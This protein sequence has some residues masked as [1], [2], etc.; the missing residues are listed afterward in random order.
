MRVFVTLILI[1]IELTVFSQEHSILFEQNIILK[2]KI[3]KVLEYDPIDSL[4]YFNKYPNGFYSI[5]DKFGRVTRSNHYS[6]FETDNIWIS[7]EFKNYYLYDSLDNKV[8]FIQIHED[9]D[10]PF[11]FIDL[12]SFDYENNK[13]KRASLESS[14]EVTSNIVFVENEIKKE[15]QTHIDTVVLNNFHKQIFYNGDSVNYLDLYLNNDQLID[16]TVY[17]GTCY[18]SIGKHDCET[19][20]IYDYYSNGVVKKKI[21]Q[22]FQLLKEWKLYSEYEYFYYQ[23]GLLDQITKYYSGNERKIISKFKYYYRNN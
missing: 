3:Y 15:K 11:R 19:K 5:Y 7:G 2:N 17:H 8:G 13:V 1:S 10:S 9:F 14:W 21:E 22:H 16:S 23:N 20:V 12:K 18:G 4:E 6:P